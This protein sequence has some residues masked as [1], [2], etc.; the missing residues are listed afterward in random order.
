L[1]TFVAARF[2]A[3]PAKIA[4]VLSS[5]D[6]RWQRVNAEA[7]AN[8]CIHHRFLA[9]DGEVL[10]VDEWESAE[11]F[12]RFF[13]SNQDIAQMMGEAGVSEEPQVSVWQPLDTPDAF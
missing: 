11:A 1:S 12:Q 2:K 3:D 8:G 13:G 9:G 6:A 5:D 10:V 7:Q 4:E